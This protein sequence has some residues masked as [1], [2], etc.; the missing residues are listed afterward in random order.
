MVPRTPS[1]LHARLAIRDYAR[2]IR[3][4]DR[5]QGAFMYTLILITY[6]VAGSGALQLST[7]KIRELGNY[8]DVTA[9]QRALTSGVHSHAQGNTP[10]LRWNMFCVPK[11]L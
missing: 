4:K 8:A 7:P 6:I 11:G 2:A 5:P 3:S 1:G 9:C 10:E